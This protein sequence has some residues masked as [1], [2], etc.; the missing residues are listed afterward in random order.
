MFFSRIV[1][2]VAVLGLAAG[3]LKILSGLSIA[4]EMF[5]PYEENLRRYGGAA[6]SSGE[7]IDRGLYVALVSLALGVLSEISFNVRASRE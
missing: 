2:I 6:A 5:G 1:R 7:I 3:V 4:T